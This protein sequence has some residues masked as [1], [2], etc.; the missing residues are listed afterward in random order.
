MNPL[1]KLIVLVSALVVPGLAASGCANEI[2]RVTDCQDICARYADC[3]DASYDV[4][5]CRSRCADSA[6]DNA[7]F[8]QRVDQCENCL[9]DRSCTSSAFACTAECA[10]IVP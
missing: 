5:A 2:D 3:F 1:T 8:D 9:D 4:G 6:R 7:S 10:T